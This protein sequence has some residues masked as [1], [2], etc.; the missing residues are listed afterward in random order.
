MPRV[1][2]CWSPAPREV[3]EWIVQLPEG[4]TV[5]DAVLASGW[6]QAAS[7]T[8]VDEADLGVWGRRCTP[9]QVLRDGDRVEVYRGLLVDPKVAR[10]ERFRKQ[11][12]RTAGL[13]A[14]RRPGA[15]PGY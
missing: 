3:L 5:R 9:D 14:K 12:A 15:K 6:P 7:G 10:R 4:G 2:V 11:G 13:F 1:T 8:S